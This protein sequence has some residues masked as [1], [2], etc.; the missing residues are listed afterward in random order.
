MIY[1]RKEQGKVSNDLYY[2][3]YLGSEHLTAKELA[4]SARQHWQIGNGLHW[5][6]DA[7]FKEDECR[8]RR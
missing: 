5:R 2:R 6:L 7:G 1:Y 8:I 3:Y 4:S